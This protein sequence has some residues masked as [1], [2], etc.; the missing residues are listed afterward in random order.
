FIKKRT[1]RDITLTLADETMPC[2]GGVV[3]RDMEKQVEVDSTLETKLDRLRE[4]I[5][6]DVA[7]ILFGDRL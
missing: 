1:R 3:V 7:K 2:L 4:G 6:V 5:R